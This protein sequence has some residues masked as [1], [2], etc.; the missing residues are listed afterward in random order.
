MTVLGR[1]AVANRSS[2]TNVGKN[3]TRGFKAL[4]A[5]WLYRRHGP[6]GSMALLDLQQLLSQTYCNWSKCSVS[7]SWPFHELQLSS[8]MI[9]RVLSRAEERD[10]AGQVGRPKDMHAE[11]QRVAAI[12]G[13]ELDNATKAFDAQEQ[14]DKAIGGGAR[15]SHRQHR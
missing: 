2:W 13:T 7:I 14:P 9:T 1:S 3:I 12:F 15:S 11:M 6:I 4:W 10:R 5:P 8:A